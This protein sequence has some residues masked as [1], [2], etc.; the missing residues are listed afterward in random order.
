MGIVITGASGFVG[1]AIVPILIQSGENLLLAGRDLVQLQE[2]FPQAKVT[3]Y[4]N[5]VNN[6]GG[7]DTLVH[8]AVRNNNISGDIEEFRKTNVTFLKEIIEHARTA[9]IKT[10]VYTTT[11]HANDKIN[12]SAYAQ[13][14]REAEEILSKVD[15]MAIINL[16]LPIVYG[17][18]FTGKLKFLEKIPK[19]IR[20]LFFQIASSLKPTVHVDKIAKTIINTKNSQHN[21]DLVISDRQ[22]RNWFYK[23]IMR[24]IDILFSLFVV[25]FLWWLLLLT[26]VIIKLSSKGPAI[27]AQKR[28]GKGG[29]LFT[30][31]KF[32]TMA[33]GTKQAGTHE[34]SA[35]RLTV[36]GK[37]LRKTK[38]DELPQIW[39]ILK[40]ELSLVGPRPCLPMQKELIVERKK[41]GV[42]DIK[43][44]ITGWAQIQG[45][46]MSDPQYLAKLDAQY[47]DLCSLLFNL[48]IIIA[49]AIGKGQGDK[50]NH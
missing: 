48:K 6:I 42:L 2:L 11:M 1:R 27:F 34:V 41:L 20:P 4:N 33:V 25:V 22:K 37:F 40:N 12:H 8:L 49:T 3:D 13:S 32:R 28:V 16:R 24:I 35:N 31:Y 18:S 30:L 7:Y 36:F 21:I 46:D 9:G 5:F 39:N 17:S 44:G 26:W 23:T 19:L 50:I 10:I 38:I 45:V 29:K 43:G 47:L 15:D 14:K